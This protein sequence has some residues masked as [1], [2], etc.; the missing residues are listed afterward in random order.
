MYLIELKFLMF[1]FTKEQKILEIGNIKIG[2]QPGF[3]PTVLFGGLFFKGNPNFDNAKI[4]IENML[5]LSKQT[6]NTAIPD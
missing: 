2:G 5:R 6:G 3:L 4:Q 1:K